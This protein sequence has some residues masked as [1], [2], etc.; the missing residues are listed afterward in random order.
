MA[1]NDPEYLIALGRYARE[2]IFAVSADGRM[3]FSDAPRILGYGEAEGLAGRHLAE[4]AHPDDLSAVL[5]ALERMR[6]GQPID[7]ALLVR[8]RHHDG[9][10][11]PLLVSVLDARDDPAIGTFL[12][13]VTRQVAEADAAEAALPSMEP[14]AEALSTGILGADG[15][16]RVVYANAAAT[17]LFWM[18]LP[19]L[20]GEGWLATVHEGDLEEVRATSKAALTALGRQD[21]TF[22]LRVSGDHIRWVHGRFQGLGPAPTGTGWVA[23]LEDVTRQRSSEAALAHRATH[24]KL[25]GLPDRLLLADRLEQAMARLQRGTEQVA[26]LYID[27]DGFKAVNDRFGHAAGD[28]V[29]I[30]VATR[31]QASIRPGD[32]ASRVGGDE[33]V[34]LAEGVSVEGAGVIGERIAGEVARPIEVS[35]HEV[36]LGTSVGLAMASAGDDPVEVV[37]R[38]DQAMYRAKRDGG[39]RVHVAADS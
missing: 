20:L 9:Y 13:R 32:T 21:V 23:I 10:W 16:E 35:G 7:Q 26:V 14:L 27:L 24:D 4:L 5:T 25:T 15:D 30:E 11:V 3:L 38:A 36:R 17:E 37:I 1:A 19:R 28:S 22:R 6:T 12:L 34:V 31:I 8:A 18:T 29:L 33:F 2:A 39:T